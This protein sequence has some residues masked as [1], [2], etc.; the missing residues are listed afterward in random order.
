M[1]VGD[2]SSQGDLFQPE[3]TQ[4]GGTSQR[5]QSAAGRRRGGNRP[6]VA[7]A[8]KSRSASTLIP[9][10][11]SPAGPVHQTMQKDLEP[12]VKMRAIRQ[13]PALR[14]QRVFSFGPAES[15]Y[16]NRAELP[17]VGPYSRSEDRHFASPRARAPRPLEQV[18]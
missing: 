8:I 5:D 10:S 2:F 12:P 7:A 13:Q 15:D 6:D 3:G 16:T 9:G 11:G 18:S 4:S 17:W 14:F 1:L